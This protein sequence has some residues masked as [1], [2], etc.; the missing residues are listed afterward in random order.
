MNCVSSLCDMLIFVRWYNYR[1]HGTGVVIY[2]LFHSIVRTLTFSSLILWYK[3][4]NQTILNI[5]MGSAVF[6]PLNC[7][8]LQ[9]INETNNINK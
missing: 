4:D 3:G 7:L 8:P 9:I 1:E 5:L 6:P 2:T